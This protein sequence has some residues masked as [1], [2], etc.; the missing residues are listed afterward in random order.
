MPT[1]MGNIRINRE[2]CFPNFRGC[3]EPSV[4]GRLNKIVNVR[5]RV[6]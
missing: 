4:L 5:Q 6:T 1:A 2:L 3:H